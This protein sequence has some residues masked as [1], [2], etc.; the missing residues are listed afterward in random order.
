MRTNEKK[1]LSL[2]YIYDT[3]IKEDPKL[4]WVRDRIQAADWPIHIAPEEGRL[5]Q[6]LIRLGGIKKIVEVGTHAGYSTMWMAMALP[7]EGHVFTIERDK[8]RISM[9]RETFLHFEEHTSKITLLEGKALD[10]LGSLEKEGPFD[11]VFI[12]ADKLNYINYLNW[13][14]KNVRSGGL[15]IGDNTFLSGAVYGKPSTERISPSALEAVNAFNKRLGN[16]SMYC[17]VMLPTKEG[18]TMGVKL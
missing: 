10:I 16:P 2:Q 15:I 17:G 4:V 11:M 8:N 14:E 3:V 7:T 18:W 13:A 6:L 9:A 1:S 5:L 12:D